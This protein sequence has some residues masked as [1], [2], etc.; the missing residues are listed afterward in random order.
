MDLFVSVT[1]SDGAA[2]GASGVGYEP[3]IATSTA[4]FTL[5]PGNFVGAPVYLFC[6]GNKENSAESSHD[7]QTPFDYPGP[8]TYKVVFKDALVW[9]SGKCTE[10]NRQHVTLSASEVEITIRD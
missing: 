8:G 1:D 2:V 5:P 3:G 4:V 9:C 6:G 7:C 10:A